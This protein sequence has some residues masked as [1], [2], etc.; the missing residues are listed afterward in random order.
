MRQAEMSK[1]VISRQNANET[2]FNKA[3]LFV[4]FTKTIHMINLTSTY[5]PSVL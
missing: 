4:S 2:P 1:K 3:G 5:D